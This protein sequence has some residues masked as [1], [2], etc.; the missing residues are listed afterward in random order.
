MV[1]REARIEQLEVELEQARE[2][3][4]LAEAQIRGL[5]VEL[6]ALRS[7]H[8]EVPGQG[9]KL[10]EAVVGAL[11]AA[12]QPLGAREVAEVLTPERGAV[13]V[14]TVAATLRYLQGRGEVVR[15]ARG[16]YTAG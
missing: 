11:E 15:V 4:A 7:S 14:E 2:R 8:D 10:T 9:T 13:A 3:K 16:R 12:G 5:S 6:E 1:G